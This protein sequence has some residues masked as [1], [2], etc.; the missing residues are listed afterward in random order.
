MFEKNKIIDEAVKIRNEKYKK[1]KND[2]TTESKIE[3]KNSKIITNQI[4]RQQYKLKEEEF[5]SEN[6]NNS[7]KMWNKAKSKMYETDKVNIEKIFY[8]N[9]FIIGSKKV[10]QSLNEY[11]QEKVKNIK[12][13]IPNQ[14]LD[15][16][17]NY[18]KMVNHPSNKFNFTEINMT[19]LDS[20]FSNLKKSTSTIDDGISM[21]MINLMKSEIKPLL[22]NLIN[23]TIRSNKF[24]QKFKISKIISH[25]KNYTHTI[26]IS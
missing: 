3:F 10:S 15:P 17:I 18:K 9:L 6:D 16:M 19:Q 1:M 4:I 20:I 21:A 5:I 25:F 2:Q 13:N 7:R 26:L 12:E 11:F 24:P 8:K 22:L 23:S 14:K